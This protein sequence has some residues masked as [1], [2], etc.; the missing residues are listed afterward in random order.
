MSPQIIAKLFNTY[1]EH[2]MTKWQPDQYYVS[3]QGFAQG[4]PTFDEKVYFYNKMT[5]K[6]FKKLHQITTS[7]KFCILDW[8]VLFSRFIFA[9]LLLS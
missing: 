1:L 2:K 3:A 6:H 8:S 9:V 4:K 5:T 7:K